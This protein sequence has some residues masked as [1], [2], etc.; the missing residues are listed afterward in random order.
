M[1][2][3][4]AYY[5]DPI[6]RKKGARIEKMTDDLAQL[7]NDMIETMRAHNGI[8][9]AAPQVHRSLA[10]FITEVPRIVSDDTEDP[11][12]EP[13]ELKIYI[14]PKIITHSPDVW[15]RDEGCLSIPGIIGTVQRPVDITIEAT[16]L[17]GVQFQEQLSWLEARAFMHENDHI[18]GVL[19]I[20]R[21]HPKDRSKLEHDLQA[22]KKKSKK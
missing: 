13:G 16:N 9:L 18:N 2:I 1:I 6:L 4:L 12:W 15:L 21:L 10:L 11:E 19:Y 3:P 17:E 7:V 8:G 5:G 14:N 22:I 20:D